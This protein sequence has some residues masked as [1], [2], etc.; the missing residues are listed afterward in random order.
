MIK[1][2]HELEGQQGFYLHHL[3]TG[4]LTQ[5]CRDRGAVD[6]RKQGLYVRL[7]HRDWL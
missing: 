1:I 3:E 7:V 5:E 6:A 4:T 2:N